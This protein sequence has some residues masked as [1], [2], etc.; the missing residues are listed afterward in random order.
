MIVNDK[1]S[2]SNSSAVGIKLSY[3][4]CD[5][6]LVLNTLTIHK[7]AG[8]LNFYLVSYC[9]MLFYFKHWLCFI[10]GSNSVTLNTYTYIYPVWQLAYQVKSADVTAVYFL[11]SHLTQHSWL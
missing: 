2:L 6:A 10:N 9:T 8:V 11:S 5:S 4:S 1:N 3:L 7:G